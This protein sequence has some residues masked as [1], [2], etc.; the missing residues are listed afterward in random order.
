MPTTTSRSP[1]PLLALGAAALLALTGCQSGG[2]DEGGDPDD[3]ATA[4]TSAAPG[5]DGGADSGAAG[6]TDDGAD[7]SA[8]EES[9]AATESEGPSDDASTFTSAEGTY[10]WQ[11]PSGLSL[12]E[13]TAEQETD[14][15]DGESSQSYPITSS[16]GL[17]Y[18]EIVINTSTD[19]GG[20]PPM[21]REVLD[22]R[23]LTDASQEDT[24][25]WAQSLLSSN[26]LTTT[27]QVPPEGSDSSD[28]AS[29]PEDCEYRVVM[30]LVSVEPDETL[31]D[32]SVW[33]FFHHTPEERAGNVIMN[34]TLPPHPENGDPTWL[35][36]EEAEELADSPAYE[37]L[38][39]L[40]TSFT[41]HEDAVEGPEE[42]QADAESGS[43]TDSSEDEASDAETSESQETEDDDG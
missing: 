18:G 1:S 17:V 29:G 7:G 36:R 33:A 27:Q 11:V 2:D 23:Q 37:R 35:S 4:G 15:P 9:P 42:S 38:W 24:E 26:C 16:D 12:G 20:A 40:F 28:D 14:W 30:N 6:S 32:S 25:T 5:E 13:N 43:P 22:S 39:E 34:A 8:G 10:S 31:E 19:A 3:G 21:Y 41:L